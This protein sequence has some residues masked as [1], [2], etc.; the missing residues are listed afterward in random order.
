[1]NIIIIV[2]A[3]AG[4]LLLFFGLLSTNKSSTKKQSPAQQER[5]KNATFEE[6]KRLSLGG[7]MT[8]NDVFAGVYIGG[9]AGSG[10][11]RAIIIKKLTQHLARYH[12]AGIIYAYKNYELCEYMIPQFGRQN[13][14]VFA[15]NDPNV[16]VKINPLNPDYF[17]DETEIRSFFQEML[18]NVSRGKKGNATAEFFNTA[19]VGLATGLTWV[20]KQ[21]APEFC[22]LPHVAALALMNSHEDLC[23]LLRAD[24][25]AEMQAS[26]YLNA[27]GDA[28]G[29]LKGTIAN[30]FGAFSTPA[31][32]YSLY[33]K[34]NNYIDLKVNYPDTPRQLFLVN[35]IT[36]EKV[37]LPVINSVLY[38]SLSLLARGQK[39]RSYTLIDE[40]STIN[41]EGFSRKPATLRALENATIF[42][43]QDLVLAV[44]QSNE[45]TPRAI[46]ANLSAQFFGKVN[47]PK[48]A[49]MYEDIV[50]LIEE[51]KTSRTTSSGKNSSSSTT[52]SKQDRKKFR[53][54]EFFRLRTGEFVTFSGGKSKKMFYDYK[55]GIEK[56]AVEPI[57]Q[58]T[59]EELNKNYEEILEWGKTAVFALKW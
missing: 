31:I 48:T 6:Y 5:C 33:D 25:R 47:D 29:S 30:F 13:C 9:A 19:A 24:I 28:L 45:T 56:E 38:L 23:N 16:T 52:V 42:A 54:D 1:M 10:K 3:G 32:F 36:N 57:R 21:R 22:S 55:H 44:E 17:P 15:P 12:F 26:N 2:V 50:E 34:D 20:L 51:K 14:D 27:T 40:G 7:G 18:Q 8:I 43:I 39:Y 49:K 58:V 11:T 4:L 59:R 37:I 41:L 53:A 35:D 46:I